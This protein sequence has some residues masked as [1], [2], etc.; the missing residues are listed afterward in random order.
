MYEQVGHTPE[1]QEAM[2][3]P[4]GAGIAGAAFTSEQTV[5]CPDCSADDRFKELPRGHRSGSIVC[6]PVMRTGEVTGVLS[7]WSTWK[8]SF[9]LAERLYFEA[10]A[11]AIA[12]LEVFEQQPE[13]A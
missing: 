10:L 9:R 13:R 3:L 1:G 8:D 4:V 12:S 6:V 7:V 5:Y 11:A 2:R